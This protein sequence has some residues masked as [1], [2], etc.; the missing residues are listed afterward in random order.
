MGAEMVN[1][2]GK[3]YSNVA[4]L[5]QSLRQLLSKKY[6]YIWLWVLYKIN[7]FLI[8]K[9]SCLQCTG[10]DKYLQMQF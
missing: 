3:F 10:T 8:T 2:L 5:T 7:P 6:K 1:Q 4:D 9:W